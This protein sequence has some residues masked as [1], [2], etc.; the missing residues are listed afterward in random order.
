MEPAPR[1]NL[2]LGKGFPMPHGDDL[3]LASFC[4]KQKAPPKCILIGSFRRAHDSQA[5]GI[6]RSRIRHWA[7]KVME[8]AVE[9][10]KAYSE[11]GEAVFGDTEL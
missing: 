10:A 2:L 1:A 9:S 7:S 8:E 5:L 11:K 3:G 6:S 4:L